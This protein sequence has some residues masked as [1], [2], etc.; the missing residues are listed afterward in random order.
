MRG[1]A[2]GRGTAVTVDNSQE[3]AFCAAT[4]V[5]R[6]LGLI[7]PTLVMHS[8][9]APELSDAV[10]IHAPEGRGHCG[11]IGVRNGSH[12]FSFHDL[13]TQFKVTINQR[14]ADNDALGY[15]V[16]VR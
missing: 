9:L 5:A 2:A 14:I 4:Q 10:S 15:K 1:R 13:R 8:K 16:F 3:P 6:L 11:K 12:I 7:S